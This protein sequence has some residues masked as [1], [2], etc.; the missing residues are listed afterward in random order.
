MLATHSSTKKISNNVF[1]IIQKAKY[2]K[3][4]GKNITNGSIGVIY[5]EDENFF[6][7]DV[8]KKE[9]KSLSE[10]DIFPYSE[11]IDGDILFK[12]S[13]IKYLFNDSSALNNLFYEVVASPGGSGALFNTF[14]N[15]LDS[16]ETVL[17][18]NYMWGSYKLMIK[19]NFGD[20]KTYNLFDCNYNFDIENFKS[21]V[22]SY[23]KKQKKLIV[24]L[25]DPC[26][27]PTGYRLSILE[28]KKI[29]D[30]LRKAC[31]LTNIILINDIAYIDFDLEKIP[32]DNFLKDLPENLLVI[33]AFS[34]SKGL[35]S[36]GLRVGAQISFSTSKKNI[37]DFH[38]A[39]MFTCRS[40]W[41]N[42]NNSGLKIF[43]NIVLNKEKYLAL[44]SEQNKVANLLK[45][46][47]Q[48]FLK[49]ADEIGLRYLPYKSGFFITIPFDKKSSIDIEDFFIKN[50]IYFLVF[51]NYIRVAICSIPT[52][53]I[54]GIA[55]KIQKAI[56]P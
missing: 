1:S 3:N 45:K 38:N 12:K 49:E 47:A 39:S 20:F 23:A 16:N 35:S 8:V 22:F 52:N 42:I 55:K 50:N 32:L 53:K 14:A 51:E 4:S 40:S 25:N 15:Y 18:P 44:R 30:I 21:L 36:Y 26:Q 24:V 11:A 27:N 29:M 17:L 34:I 28:I 54:L 9:F 19:E 5:D 56:T 33:F 43:S 6:T 31:K 13:V 41:S 7:F 10:L 48:I 2:A 46:R 37:A